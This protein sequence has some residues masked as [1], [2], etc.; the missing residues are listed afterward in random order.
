MNNKTFNF[1]QGRIHL[2]N[3][4]GC[5]KVTE[6]PLWL[7]SVLPL[8][9]QSYLEVGCAT[10]VLSLILKLKAPQAQ[11]TAIDIQSCMIEQ[12]KKH[13]LDNNINNIDFKQ[14]NLFLL[15]D[16]KQYD[17]V[18]SNPP[19]F[20]DCCCDEIIDKIKGIAHL[21]A[22]MSAFIDKQLSLVRP[23]GSLYFMGHL[24]TRDEI[25]EKFKNNINLTE[26][27]LLSS[28]IKPAK[29]FIYII[30]KDSDKTFEQY[31]LNSFK[32]DLRQ[33]ILFLYHS[34]TEKYLIKLN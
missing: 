34:L 29:R 30:K 1:Y 23:G 2:Q 5:Y 13:A 10:G 4:P 33:E 15:N 21:Q 25:L 3:G 19:F 14:E 27:A 18:F 24:S 31:S 12:A 8:N 20:D 17:C 28:E 16:D 9:K 22:N 7:L 11:I 6:D 32:D 26:I